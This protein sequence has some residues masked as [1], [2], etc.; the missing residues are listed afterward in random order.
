[1]NLKRLWDTENKKIVRAIPTWDPHKKLQVWTNDDG[2]KLYVYSNS[3]YVELDTS[4]ATVNEYWPTVWKQLTDETVGYYLTNE[5]TD[6][7]NRDEWDEATYTFKDYDWTVLKTGKVEEGETPTPPADPT[8]EATAQYTYTFAGWNPTVWPISKKTTYTATYTATVN[9]YT[10]TFAT[11]NNTL[12]T[13][14]PASVANVPYGTAITSSSNTVT[15]GETTATATAETWAEFTSWSEIPSTVTENVTITATFTST[16]PAYSPVN[17]LNFV[18]EQIEQPDDP[19]AEPI[20]VPAFLRIF[21]KT[22]V[23]ETNYI[24][25]SWD[26]LDEFTFY[27]ACD[28]Q[29]VE[30]LFGDFGLGL[31]SLIVNAVRSSLDT[32]T[33]TDLTFTT[34]AWSY[35]NGYFAGTYTEQEA[36]GWIEWIIQENWLVPW[37]WIIETP[38]E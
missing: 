24:K 19:E 32:T 11:N 9:K 20:R 33:D 25:Y 21:Y 22:W 34:D 10:V 26:G 16:T 6:L 31:A 23:D 4:N 38:W 12:G 14:S 29:F 15:V 1:M 36:F 27:W 30:D 13:V 28:T 5:P 17:N 18:A 37:M 3:E 8:R 7:F 2:S 35:I